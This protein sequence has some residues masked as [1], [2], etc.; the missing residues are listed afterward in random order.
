MPKY[1]GS[2]FIKQYTRTTN[3]PTWFINPVF[4]HWLSKQDPDTAW[5]N[6]EEANQDFHQR[7]D[8]HG[9]FRF[10]THHFTRSKPY[11]FSTHRTE[12]FL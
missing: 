2:R 6:M 1:A 11:S 5:Y 7:Y 9:T 12:Y 3:Q 8:P 10:N 4:Q